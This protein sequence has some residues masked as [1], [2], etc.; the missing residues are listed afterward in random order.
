MSF[1]SH[2]L[3]RPGAEMIALL[4]VALLAGCGA[5]GTSAPSTS[6]PGTP[7]GTSAPGSGTA[8]PTPAAA[9]LTTCVTSAEI[10][11]LTG[12]TFPAPQQSSSTGYL[13]C[14]YNDPTSGAT[15]VIEVESAPGTSDSALQ[16]A[17]SAGASAFNVTATSVSGLG[18]AAYI[19]TGD[20]ASTNASGVATT[21]LEVLDGSELVDVTAGL[22][23]AA[24]ESVASYVL[25]Q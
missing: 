9:V 25:A 6:P 8:T 20:D 15:L 10:A 18:D 7:A 11:T 4:S 2:T 12:T 23:P 13:L 22:T 16:I 14:N 19:F 1:H 24:V 3:R 21:G 5:S 17:A